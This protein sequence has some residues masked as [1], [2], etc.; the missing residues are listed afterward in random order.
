MRYGMNLGCRDGLPHEVKILHESP[1]VKWEVC[2]RCNKKF[3]WI[4]GF[5]ERINNTEYLKVHVRNYAQK[6]G[7]TK[8]IYHKIYQPE[9]CKIVI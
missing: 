4:K 3:R 1:K 8:R 2:V 9:K 7:V 5:K 6:F